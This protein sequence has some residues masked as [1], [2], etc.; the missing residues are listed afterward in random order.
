[1]SPYNAAGVLRDLSL[2]DAR[3]VRAQR[4]LG[5]EHLL[6]DVAADEYHDAFTNLYRYSPLLRR[7]LQS[8]GRHDREALQRRMPLGESPPPMWDIEALDIGLRGY[9]ERTQLWL[10]AGLDEAA[11][12]EIANDPEQR[13]DYGLRRVLPEGPDQIR[14]AAV[15]L[16]HYLADD[17]WLV[18]GDDHVRP[19]YLQPF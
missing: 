6:G 12:E 7:E 1:M 2:L 9:V 8:L 13:W 17:G 11:L 4:E 15:A 14:R 19:D 18:G 10:T 5:D 3:I 16:F